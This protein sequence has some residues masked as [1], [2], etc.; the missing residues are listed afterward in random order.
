MRYQN[1]LVL[2]RKMRCMFLYAFICKT[3]ARCAFS[4]HA[5]QVVCSDPTSVAMALQD[6]LATALPL[7]WSRNSQN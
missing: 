3:I 7:F 4:S 6:P 5:T 1:L 2:K